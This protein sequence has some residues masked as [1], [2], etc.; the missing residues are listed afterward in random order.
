VIPGGG[1]PPAVERIISNSERGRLHD[2]KAVEGLP[3]ILSV[4]GKLFVCHDYSKAPL[5]SMVLRSP[6]D[7][8]F[9]VDSD[10]M[11]TAQTTQIRS[12]LYHFRAVTR[13]SDY[14]GE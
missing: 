3:N 8:G 4:T 14:K 13:L 5:T 12:W 9:V 10:D 11:M 2:N 1:V 7:L 6:S